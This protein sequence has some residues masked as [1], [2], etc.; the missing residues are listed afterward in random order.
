MAGL[1]AFDQFMDFVEGGIDAITG[2]SRARPQTPTPTNDAPA[3][4]R[5]PRPIE[6]LEV[7]DAHT[8]RPIFIVKV[9][10]GDTAEC[11]SRALADRIKR[12]LEAP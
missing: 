3:A 10:D 4:P 7:I 2:T 6:I 11:S 8:S 5:S 12:A 9:S 1:G